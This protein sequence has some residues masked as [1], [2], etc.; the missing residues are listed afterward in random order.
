MSDIG[1]PYPRKEG[2]FNPIFG[3][4]CIFVI[5]V[6]LLRSIYAKKSENL[7]FKRAYLSFR[8]DLIR[9]KSE[10]VLN[11]RILFYIAIFK[12]IDSLWVVLSSLVLYI[13][14]SNID[15][16]NILYLLTLLTSLILSK[17]RKSWFPFA[18]LSWSTFFVKYVLQFSFIRQNLSGNYI[19]QLLGVQKYDQ[20]WSLDAFLSQIIILA[21]A[22]LDGFL[23]FESYGAGARHG[24]ISSSENREETF[25]LLVS[26]SS[27]GSTT[28]NTKQSNNTALFLSV[29]I[30]LFELIEDFLLQNGLSICVYLLL[31][32]SFESFSFI[33]L[34]YVTLY[35]FYYVIRRKNVTTSLIFVL[36]LKLVIYFSVIYQYILLL[37][38]ES[39]FDTYKSLYHLI[40]ASWT[41]YLLINGL[42]SSNILLEV[43][44][45][46]FFSLC[47]SRTSGLAEF[48]ETE[49][50][51]W[52]ESASMQSTIF[53]LSRNLNLAIL[54][55]L[56]AL[57]TTKINLINAIYISFTMVLLIAE[58]VNIE[59]YWK[60]LSYLNFV[61][62]LALQI[63][64]IPIVSRDIEP[65][66]YMFSWNKTIGIENYHDFVVHFFRYCTFILYQ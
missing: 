38:L 44:A 33:S 1:L 26:D 30:Y 35:I 15:L 7:K 18:I 56:F 61:V 37:L 50:L 14:I 34:I 40:P 10:G 66:Q 51:K 2:Y 27:D 31:L 36:A 58:N 43:I 8:T 9:L 57:L 39:D 52:T 65:A 16:I 46:G 28:I 41:E 13:S 21:F 64:Q 20:Y 12:L 53:F 4:T 17:C 60:F 6:I 45:L 59:K 11:Q 19:I 42:T 47:I 55:V 24:S 54:V 63:Y 49:F 25:P 62:L 22:Y 23:R 3:K 29:I 48:T 32:T 5:N